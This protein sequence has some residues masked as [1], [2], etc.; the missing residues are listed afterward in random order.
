MLSMIQPSG[1]VEEAIRTTMSWTPNPVT[2]RHIYLGWSASM[3]VR[4]SF[5]QYKAA[6]MQTWHKLGVGEGYWV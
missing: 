1:Q 2:P 5:A 4:D 6:H 3:G